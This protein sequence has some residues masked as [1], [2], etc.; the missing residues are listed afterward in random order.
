MIC[1]IKD[2][3]PGEGKK[4]QTIFEDGQH[5]FPPNKCSK[6]KKNAETGRRLRK[7]QRRTNSPKDYSTGTKLQTEANGNIQN[8]NQNQMQC[9]HRWT[10]ILRSGIADKCERR[11]KCP[12]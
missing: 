5:L 12:A 6:N 3:G 1:S 10:A 2:L 9:C 8:G 7:G 11:D 4:S